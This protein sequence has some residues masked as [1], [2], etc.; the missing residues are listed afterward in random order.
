[1]QDPKRVI[2]IWEETFEASF[3]SCMFWLYEEKLHYIGYNHDFLY[4]FT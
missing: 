4:V 1:M 2:E 3:K